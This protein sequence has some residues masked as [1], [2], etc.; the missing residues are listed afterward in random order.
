MAV[1][2]ENRAHTDEQ[3]KARSVVPC[4]S[5]RDAVSSRSRPC[6]AGRGRAS[7]A[8]VE[9]APVDAAVGSFGALICR[10]LRGHERGQDRLVD[11]SIVSTTSRGLRPSRRAHRLLHDTADRSVR[12]SPRTM[13]RLP[14][15]LLL[16]LLGCD[17]VTCQKGGGSSR[18]TPCDAL[19]L[20][21]SRVCDVAGVRRAH[22]GAARVN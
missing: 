2:N 10:E 20:S 21:A 15:L 4:L 3:Q 14:S 13:A 12:R 11:R 5:A 18:T 8:V 16:L 17:T 6:V 9:Q 22:R 19:P 7:S 1:E